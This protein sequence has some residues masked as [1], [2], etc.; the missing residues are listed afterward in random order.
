MLRTGAAGC[1]SGGADKPRPDEQVQ[2]KVTLA[3]LRIYLV[4]LNLFAILF[5][6]LLQIGNVPVLYVFR[7]MQGVIAGMY[8]NFIPTYIS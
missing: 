4:F 5:T 6:A 3:Q 1:S 8:M 7:I 2:Q